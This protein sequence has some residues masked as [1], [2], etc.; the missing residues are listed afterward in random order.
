SWTAD[1]IAA[2]CY[3]HYRT[4]L[5]KQGQPDPS[6]EWTLLAAVVQVDGAQGAA[7][8]KKVVALGTGT[9]CIGQSRLSKTGDILQDSHAEIIAKRSFQRYLLHQLALALESQDS[10][11]VPG[12]ESRK[13]TMRAGVS[14]VFFTSHTPCGDASIIPMSPPEDQLCPTS[15]VSQKTSPVINSLNS[16]CKRKMVDCDPSW[17][18]KRVKQEG[19]E[20]RDESRDQEEGRNAPK[21]SD[22]YRTG[23]K[24]V[25]G[26]AQ[27]S[28]NPGWTITLWGCSVSSQ[29]EAIPLCPC[30]AAIRWPDG[31]CS[32]ARGRYL[33]IFCNSP[34][35]LHR[36]WLESVHSAWRQWRGLCTAGAQK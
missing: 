32:A 15:I 23:A 28:R 21:A 12:S 35:T 2:L 13:W 27:D 4:G 6:R 33:C 29:A 3:R 34:S 36:L 19:V 18:T 31:T 25:P 17:G 26:E 16:G 7:C 1:E 11:L 14:F 30:P 9:K 22:I 5:P 10:V 24:C 20:S 8:T